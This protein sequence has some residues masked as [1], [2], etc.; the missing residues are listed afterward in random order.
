MLKLK[1]IPIEK[2]DMDMPMM[3]KYPPTVHFN[4][5]QV[6]EI[7]DWS[8]GKTYQVV[9][10][11]KQTSMNQNKDKSVDAN[12]EVVAYKCVEDSEDMSD[13]DIEKLQGKALAS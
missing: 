4:D 8:V 12:F 6:P 5:S 13:E 1:K 2:N 9:L 7:K 11:I 3:G 10:E